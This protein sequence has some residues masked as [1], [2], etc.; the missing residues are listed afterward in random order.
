MLM[1]QVNY[2][3]AAKICESYKTCYRH[4]SHTRHVYYLEIGSKEY[5][6]PGFIITDIQKCGKADL[7]GCNQFYIYHLNYN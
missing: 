2:A 7:G 1:N 6:K 5:Q 3:L 4:V